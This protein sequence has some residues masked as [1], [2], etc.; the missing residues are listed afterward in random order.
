MSVKKNIFVAGHRGMVGS[1]IVRNLAKDPN[2]R[3]LTVSRDELDLTNQSQ[4]NAFFCERVNRTGLPC[5]SKGR[6][7]T[8]QQYL[9]CGFYLSEPDDRGEHHSCGTHE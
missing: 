5:S 4:V 9:P 6:W 3:I 1:A 8:R 2:N 7:H